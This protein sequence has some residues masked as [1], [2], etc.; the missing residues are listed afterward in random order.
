M[1]NMARE[2]NKARSTVDSLVP[3]STAKQTLLDLQLQL[4]Q[5]QNET[6][7]EVEP[8]IARMTASMTSLRQMHAYI[9]ESI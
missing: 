2:L 9:S 7:Q 8:A 3:I 1:E 5:L 4:T 6:R